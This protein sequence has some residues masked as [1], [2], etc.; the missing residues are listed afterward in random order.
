MS[1]IVI[2]LCIFFQIF[3]FFTEINSEFL[4]SLILQNYAKYFGN[5]SSIQANTTKTDKLKTC[6]TLI[7]I[8]P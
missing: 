7:D 6:P 5:F 1:F 3:L 2:L 8:Q 4:V